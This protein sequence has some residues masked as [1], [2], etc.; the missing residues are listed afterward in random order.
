[1]LSQRWFNDDP[2]STTLGQQQANFGSLIN[3]NFLACLKQLCH[4]APVNH[5]INIAAD[6]TPVDVDHAAHA[7]H[8]IVHPTIFSW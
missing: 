4:F 3:N 7:C 5:N 6:L 8:C 1:M 2:S